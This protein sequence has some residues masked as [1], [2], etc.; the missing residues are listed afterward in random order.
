MPTNV[1]PAVGF[2]KQSA[3]SDINTKSDVVERAIRLRTSDQFRE[4]IIKQADKALETLEKSVVNNVYE[5]D[6]FAEALTKV[7]RIGARA[8]GYDREGDHPVINIGILGTGAEYES[9]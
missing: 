4:R 7:E 5:T 8:Y 3:V 6:R 2:D 1:D 9:T